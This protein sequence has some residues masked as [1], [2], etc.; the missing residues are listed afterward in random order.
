M[1]QE[2]P[3]LIHFE[4]RRLREAG[5]KPRQIEKILQIPRERVA[6]Y[7]YKSKIVEPVKSF[8][9]EIT[10]RITVLVNFGYSSN[11]IAEDLFLPIGSIRQTI[12]HLKSTN[13]ITKRV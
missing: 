10:S 7:L 11:E 4:V 12:N 9:T 2:Q 13:R 5:H 6:Y 8:S 1:T 3:N